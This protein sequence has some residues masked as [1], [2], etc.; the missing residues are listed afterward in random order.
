MK[1]KGLLIFL[2]GMV[3]TCM[4]A[5]TPPHL[6]SPQ[7]QSSVSSTQTFRWV[8]N[9]ALKTHELKIYNCD[10]E[11]GNNLQS[12]RLDEYRLTKFNDIGNNLPVSGL[13]CGVEN[14]SPLVTCNSGLQQ[15][16]AYGFSLTNITFNWLA[17][18][19][20]EAYSGIT[21]LKNGNYV[22]AESDQNYI[23]YVPY[24]ANSGTFIGYLKTPEYRLNLGAGNGIQG[25]TYNPINNKIY[26]AQEKSPIT[27][28]E[29]SG[30]SAPDFKGTI[31][32]KVPFDMAKA[33][34]NWNIKSVNGLFHLAQDLGLN[35]T[36]TAEHLLVLS[37][38]SNVVIETDMKGNEISRLKLGN[39]GA[40]GTLGSAL[41]EASGIAYFNGSVFITTKSEVDIGRKAKMY[42]FQNPNHKNPTAS[43]KGTPVSTQ[44][45]ISGSSTSKN[46]SSLAK[47]KTYC[48]E[49]VGTDN[50]NRTVKSSIRSFTTGAPLFGC[51]E[52]NACNYNPAATQ[53]DNSCEVCKITK[54]NRPSTGQKYFPGSSINISWED[55]FSGNVKIQLI[56]VNDT[57][58]IS[59]STPSDGSYSYTIPNNIK[60]ATN[61]RV[62]I[63]KSDDP[64]VSLY[65]GYF[66]IEDALFINIYSP[67][68]Q[69]KYTIGED[70]V[71]VRWEH[72][73]TG[74]FD[75]SL[76]KG[77]SFIRTVG[78]NVSLTYLNYK[79][80]TSLSTGTNYRFL[81]K[82]KST[83]VSEYSPYITFEKVDI[84]PPNSIIVTDP[85]QNSVYNV[86]QQITIK[87]IKT[88]TEPVDIFLFKGDSYKKDIAK[89]VSGNS[90]RY[91][92]DNLEEAYNYNI[93][94]RSTKNANVNDYGPN[95]TLLETD[96][97]VS[98]PYAGNTYRA[99]NY[100]SVRWEDASSQYVS[101]KLYE[102]NRQLTTIAERV[103]NNGAYSFPAPSVKTG[104]NYTVVVTSIENSS[105][106]GTSGKFTIMPNAGISNFTLGNGSFG[107]NKVYSNKDE[108]NVTWNDNI[109]GP[110][111][112]QLYRDGKYLLGLTGKTSSD[113]KANIV[114]SRRE[115][116]DYDNY[117][118]IIVSNQDRTI[119]KFSHTIS[120]V[121]R[122]GNKDIS[123]DETKN[124][125]N[126]YPNPS[127]GLFSI[128][129]PDFS[130]KTNELRLSVFNALGHAILKNNYVDFRNNKIDLNLANEPKGLY[131]INLSNN[132]K[133]YHTKVLLD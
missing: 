69:S 111:R 57:R 3:C 115:I 34:K 59:N 130:N 42:L 51:T 46:L 29:F 45:G 113:G 93:F 56:S 55:N 1:K 84:P 66:T 75:V 62:L 96:I 54:I 10:F 25:I 99:G 38:E 121:R 82:S 125:L 20:L 77:N 47:N 52:P 9:E 102:N 65:S 24:E 58:T 16:N 81:V 92:F 53:N 22:L 103:P 11:I 132:E 89:N 48:W 71:A 36:N 39:G 7:N 116:P 120:I 112:I 104:S 86:G 23:Y 43:L 87:W 123:I 126:V 40:N 78:S 28:H 119:Y 8:S 97:K 21:H 95:F 68:A 98:S 35:G 108:F 124:L 61:F 41:A 83:N 127:N 30:F 129:I 128:D 131:L 2:M 37:A 110:V 67:T 63:Q 133:T 15:L 72:N 73:L 19:P 32:L 13:A 114:L 109:S 94:V 70:N 76:Y 122:N 31:S 60:P 33:A 80:P 74:N 79:L 85:K 49:I 44:K 64:S 17:G 107:N 91:K 14:Q 18:F 6:T 118:L 5:T 88:F 90:Y 117:N 100:I 105:K 101:I 26:V 4:I 12:L 27:L 106:K 50:Q